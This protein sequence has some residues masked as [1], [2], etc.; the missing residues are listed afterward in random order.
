MAS[1]DNTE[2]NLPG[3]GIELMI[4]GAVSDVSNHYAKSRFLTLLHLFHLVE[5]SHFKHFIAT[6]RK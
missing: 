1:V 4:S 6:N 2:F 5:N 3:P